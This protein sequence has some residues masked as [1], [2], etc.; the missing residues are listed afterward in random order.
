MCESRSRRE[1]QA[2]LRVA[3]S[4]ELETLLDIDLDACRLFDQVG[5][6]LTPAHSAEFSARE[7]RRWAQC[8]NAG[9]V[10]VA[11]DR[12]GAP[13]GFAALAHLDGEPYLEQ[14]SVRVSAMR[15][16]IG[17]A[18][19]TAAERLAAKGRTRVLWLTT[20]SH[21]P[22]N[23]P[24]YERAGFVAIPV[25]ECGTEMLLELFFQRRLLPAP[26]KRVVMRKVLKPSN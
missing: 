2:D 19:L 7:R 21:L 6:E 20:Y 26:D 9:T 11:S 22:W 4:N 14:L 25:K 3:E 16:G 24:F 23:A 17:S 12:S 15:Q 18:L 5:L 10:L 13:V 1:Y 8:L